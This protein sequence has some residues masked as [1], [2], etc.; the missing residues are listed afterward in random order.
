MFILNKEQK[1][2][3]GEYYFYVAVKGVLEHCCLSGLKEKDTIITKEEEAKILPP[4]K[5]KTSA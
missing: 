3:G 4:E 1:I 2:A 5:Q